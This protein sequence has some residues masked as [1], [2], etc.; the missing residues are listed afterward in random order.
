M[1][2]THVNNGLWVI[3]MCHVGPSTVTNVS[4]WGILIM[5]K[6]MQ[7]GRRRKWQHTPIFFP[8]NPVDTGA[9][10]AT[11]HGAAT[12]SDTTAKQQGMYGS[13]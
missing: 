4:W 6:A 7:F 8:G 10:W 5:G 11:V 3:M 2:N 1:C 12:E 9:W 13:R